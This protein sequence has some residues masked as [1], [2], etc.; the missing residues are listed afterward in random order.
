MCSSACIHFCT[1]VLCS[2]W[3]ACK[4]ANEPA[5]ECVAAAC[6]YEPPVDRAEWE[7]AAYGGLPRRP[8]RTA[9]CHALTKAKGCAGAICS[10][11]D[12]I[13][14]ARTDMDDMAVNTEPLDAALNLDDMHDKRER[15]RMHGP[16]EYGVPY[17]HFLNL[18]TRS[19]FVVAPQGASRQFA[20]PPSI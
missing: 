19:A 6:T 9:A 1:C 5:L 8:D 14:R 11:R 4:A 3:T 16:V 17:D 7:L 10:V 18:T 20:T 15:I 2:V 13:T 12:I